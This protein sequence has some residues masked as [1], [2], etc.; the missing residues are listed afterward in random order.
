MKI[1]APIIKK[2][3]FKELIYDGAKNPIGFISICG[4]KIYYG[5]QYKKLSELG[6]IG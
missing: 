5:S 2:I 6:M 3:K 1:K 4:K